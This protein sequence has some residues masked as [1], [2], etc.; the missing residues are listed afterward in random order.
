MADFTEIIQEINTNIPDNNT[1]SITAAKLRTTLIDLT[2]TIDNQQDSFET[3]INNTLDNFV[4]DSLV[5]DDTDKSLSAKQGQELK[6]RAFTLPFVGNGNTSVSY[7]IYCYAGHKYRI[8]PS[9]TDVDFSGI[10][11]TSSTYVLLGIYNYDENGDNAETLYSRGCNNKTSPY[12]TYYD[13]TATQNGYIGIIM[14]ATVG[15][16]V[17]FIVTDIT[18]STEIYQYIDTNIQPMQTYLYGDIVD[19]DNLVDTK[20]AFYNVPLSQS[21]ISWRSIGYTI[22]HSKGIGI[23]RFANLTS[24]GYDTVIVTANNDWDAYVTFTNASGDELGGDKSLTTLLNNNLIS[25]VHTETAAFLVPAGSTKQFSIPQDC[26]NILFTGINYGQTEPA[27]PTS[28][29]WRI[30]SKVQ[31]AKSNDLGLVAD[32]QIV[33]SEIEE[34]K[35]TEQ[36]N[37][38]YVKVDPRQYP[39]SIYLITSYGTIYYT[40]DYYSVEIP[41]YEAKSVKIKSLGEAR[42]NFLKEKLESGTIQPATGYNNLYRTQTP[43]TLEEYAVPEDAKYLY[44]YIGS[45]S[46]YIYSKN[47]YTPEYIE[48]N[49]KKYVSNSQNVGFEE[50][51][52]GLDGFVHYDSKYATTGFIDCNRGFYLKLNDEYEVYSASLYDMTGQL[53]SYNYLPETDYYFSYAFWLQDY[54]F[55]SIAYCIPYQVRVVCRRRDGG[56]IEHLENIAKSFV[57]LNDT[58]LHLET[59]D[60]GLQYYTNFRNRIRQLSACMFNPQGWMPTTTTKSEVDGHPLYNMNRQY[61]RKNQLRAGVGYSANLE[62]SKAVGM[63]VGL[64]TYL[65]AIA[66][67]YSLVYTEKLNSNTS[68]YNISYTIR[69]NESAVNYYGIVCSSLVGYALNMKMFYRAD[70]YKDAKVP[71]T[72]LVNNATG[73]NVKVGDLVWNDGHIS[74]ISEIFDDEQGNRKF[75]V[76][77]EQTKPSPYICAI[78]PEE[79]DNRLAHYNYG[80]PNSEIQVLRFNNWEQV[81][82]PY[83]FAEDAEIDIND[84]YTQSPIYEPLEDVQSFAGDYA[85]FTIGTPLFFTV[86]I[87]KGYTK[88]EIFDSNGDLYGQPIDIT[89]LTPNEFYWGYNDFGKLNYSSNDL[90]A[91]VYTARLSNADGTIVSPVTHFEM[92]AMTFNVEKKTDESNQTYY[93]CTFS[94]SSNATPYLL[95]RED[96]AGQNVANT[97]TTHPYLILDGTETSADVYWN[98]NTSYKYIKLFCKGNYGVAVTKFDAYNN[99]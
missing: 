70:F 32:M 42:F 26:I 66:D 38:E 72:S 18:E 89:E 33:K 86:N 73:Q 16:E 34:I 7:K 4:V 63:E 88:M 22:S 30:P 74:V 97:G 10:T 95:R 12:D 21:N 1:Q 52:I 62:Y 47:S 56:D 50:G 39:L 79:F 93:H 31:M 41:L 85:V 40:G 87:S 14:R 20:G 36:S 80:Q 96:S 84:F 19:I 69:S 35:N 82:T 5:S 98:I 57:Y 54:S 91:G 59:P 46:R 77:S 51:R 15:E 6:N 45:L 90:V 48:I 78:T 92:V 8:Y 17:T 43:N 27:A 75:I 28:S 94:C 3:T 25:N 29:P 65:T 24:E 44:L 53:V 76:W 60:F 11:Y 64:K 9:R 2:N 71:N 67:K 55:Y 49:S 81:D 61:F 58:R 99:A 23:T 83:N 13:V 37:Y 68:D